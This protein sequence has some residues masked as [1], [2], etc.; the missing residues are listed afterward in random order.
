MSSLRIERKITLHVAILP[1]EI[2]CQKLDQGHARLA[3]AIALACGTTAA[4]EID[5]ALL[6][7]AQRV[8]SADTLIVLDAAV[9]TALL[10]Q[11]GDYLA[12]RR[13]LVDTLR[14]TADVSQDPLRHWLDERGIAYRSFW[15]INMIQAELTPVQI[16]GTG[17]ARRCGTAGREYAWRSRCACPRLSRD[18]A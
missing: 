3:V 4:A 18:A 7:Q 6:A 5:P 17:R 10:R 13:N 16:D 15:I 2:R 9:P 11:D 14:A 12:R 1:G 8:G